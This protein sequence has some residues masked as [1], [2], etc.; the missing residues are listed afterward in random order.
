MKASPVLDTWNARYRQLFSRLEFRFGRKDLRVRAEG[1]LRR[2]M[3]RVERKNFWQLAEAVDD[4]LDPASAGAC[5][6]GCRCRA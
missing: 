5:P 1:Y 6:L 4:A 2:L 3:G